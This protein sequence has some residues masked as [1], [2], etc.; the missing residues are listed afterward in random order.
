MGPGRSWDRNELKRPTELIV[1]RGRDI[2]P[3]RK[4][5]RVCAQNT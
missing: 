1:G 2:V 3:N 4:R 5:A